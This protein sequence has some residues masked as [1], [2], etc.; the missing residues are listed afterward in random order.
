MAKAR[1][2]RRKVNG[3]NVDEHRLVMEQHL[4]RR[5]QSN[6]YIHH[7]NEDNFD[8]RIE[9]LELMTPVQHG[10]YHHLKYP[11]VKLCVICGNEFTP[12]KTKRRRKRTCSKKCRYLLIAKTREENAGTG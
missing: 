10:R 11:L 6:E 9:N 8:N 12:H 4:G 7:E 1:Y 2:K 5:L 3:R